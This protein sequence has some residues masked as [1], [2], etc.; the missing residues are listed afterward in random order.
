MCGRLGARGAVDVGSRTLPRQVILFFVSK[1]PRQFVVTTIFRVPFPAI[2]MGWPACS[3]FSEHCAR[4]RPMRYLRSLL[5]LQSTFI[6]VADD[7]ES[8]DRVQAIGCQ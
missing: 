4:T 7:V 1:L 8:G 2:T 6:G 5:S 3:P